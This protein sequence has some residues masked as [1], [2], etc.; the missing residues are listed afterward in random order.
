M[1][2]IY[3]TPVYDGRTKVWRILNLN[4]GSVYSTEYPSQVDALN[5][6]EGGTVRAGAV[7]T[8]ISL[9]E[10]RGRLITP[11]G[12]W[13]AM[14]AYAEQAHIEG[15]FYIEDAGGTVI[16]EGLDKVNAE[17]IVALV[18]RAFP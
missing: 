7:V 1:H 4:S 17:L 13:K 3:E 5:I 15:P 8:H 16:A 10:I 11:T 2:R 6:I 18:N 12:P 9:A 14:E